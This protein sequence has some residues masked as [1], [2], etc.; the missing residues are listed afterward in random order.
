M[1][2]D[3]EVRSMDLL[4]SM[5][6]RW[7]P[8]AGKCIHPTLF[9]GRG[10]DDAPLILDADI[11]EKAVALELGSEGHMRIGEQYKYLCSFARHYGEPIEVGIEV[12]GR[13]EELL[14]FHVVGE[15]SN[16]R[17]SAPASELV[18]IFEDLR[19]PLI[20]KTKQDIWDD[21]LEGGYDGILLETWS[22]WHPGA[23]GAPC[24][25]CF[26]CNGRHSFEVL[27]EV[28]RPYA[29][30]G[31]GSYSRWTDA[32]HATATAQD[33]CVL[34]TTYNREP[35]LLKVLGDIIRDSKG[36]KVHVSVWEDPSEASYHEVKTLAS[37]YGWDFTTMRNRY[38]K[39]GYTRFLRDI[40]LEAKRR[41]KARYFYFMQDDVELCQDFFKRTTALWEDVDDPKKIC[42]FLLKTNSWDEV[43]WTGAGQ[44]KDMGPVYDLGWLDCNAFLFQDA[45]LEEMLEL[46]EP[47]GS[48]FKPSRLHLRSSGAGRQMSKLLYGKDLKLLGSKESYVLHA[49]NMSLL[50]PDRAGFPPTIDLVDGFFGD[51]S[52]QEMSC[53]NMV[54]ASLASIPSREAQLEVVVRQMLPQV[55]K[56][57]VYLNGYE[58]VPRFLKHDRIVVR[59]SQT[60]EFGDQG[61]AGK[62]YW[63][64]DVE[65][66]HFTIDDD[67]KFLYVGQARTQKPSRLR[68][69][70]EFQRIYAV[71]RK[72]PPVLRQLPPLTPSCGEFFYRTYLLGRDA[73]PYLTRRNVRSSC[74]Y[75]PRTCNRPTANPG[76]GEDSDSGGDGNV[77][78]YDDPSVGHVPTGTLRHSVVYEQYDSG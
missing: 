49:E 70:T 71:K 69:P 5:L 12:G 63:A 44:A 32:D 9:V 55:G 39:R 24:G 48:W 43:R 17:V 37:R 56:L 11:E 10:Q 33:I 28:E 74:Y 8:K 73:R 68:C 30:L 75:G 78:F 2:R 66:Y 27:S 65:G 60:C 42:L 20:R 14:R 22:C 1:S 45:F 61:D 76:S 53:G 16:C 18:T 35:G 58:K 47:P 46:Q 4:R 38:G 7:H 13:A 51:E 59:Q 31:E 67:L 52:A 3:V 29:S 62:F 77:V 6:G 34:I 19:F 50:N 15:G 36:Y 21:A 57:N 40:F 25:R 64:D 72:G 54:T 23:D 41:Y 26:A